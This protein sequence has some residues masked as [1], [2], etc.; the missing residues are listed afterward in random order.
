M[1]ALF[2]KNLD[3]DAAFVSKL[4][5]ELNKKTV[6]NVGPAQNPSEDH[7][8]PWD[9]LKICSLCDSN[10]F[11]IEE[12]EY[13][14]G[15]LIT[16]PYQLNSIQHL[17]L[18]EGSL[19]TENMPIDQ[20]EWPVMV[21]IKHRR[22]DAISSFQEGRALLSTSP[23]LDE[24][25]SNLIEFVVPLDRDK[26]SG[27]DSSLARGVIFRTFPEGRTGLLAGFQ[28]APWLGAPGRYELVQY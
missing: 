15:D 11:D 6:A 28:L 22:Q 2:G 1:P 7:F 18:N 19:I 8:K 4:W 9:C 23:F 5:S 10:S 21:D 17:L 27:Y 13:R 20:S 16:D 3:E 26:P 14:K 12:M 24:L 25:Y